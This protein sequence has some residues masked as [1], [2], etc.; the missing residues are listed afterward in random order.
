M[1]NDI[2]STIIG[3]HDNRIYQID[4]HIS[5]NENWETTCADIRTQFGNLVEFI[6]L[7]KNEGRLLI[8]WPAQCRVRQHFRH[9]YFGYAFY[10]YITH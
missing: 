9:R 7:E 6:T 4:Y 1:G 3:E 5:V 8:K 2:T 10:K